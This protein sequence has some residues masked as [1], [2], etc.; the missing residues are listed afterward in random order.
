[1][2]QMPGFLVANTQELFAAKKNVTGFNPGPLIRHHYEKTWI[3]R[4]DPSPRA[5]LPARRERGSRAAV[6]SGNGPYPS[7]NAS[8][9][10]SPAGPTSSPTVGRRER[11]RG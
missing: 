6:G 8:P 4:S 7:Q 5:P 3:G 10:L 2:D 9:L 11:R 1:M